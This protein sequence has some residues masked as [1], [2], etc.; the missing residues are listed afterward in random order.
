MFIDILPVLKDHLSL[1]T[2]CG[3]LM[4]VALPQVLWLCDER[5]QDLQCIS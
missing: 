1:E 4:Q 2:T 3:Q 5:Q